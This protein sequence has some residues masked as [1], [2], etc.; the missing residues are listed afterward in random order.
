MKYGKGVG[1]LV[2]T[3]AVLV[4]GVIDGGVTLAEWLTVGGALA[5]TIAVVALPNLPTSPAVKTV[6]QG[7]S[8]VAS[9]LAAALLDPAGITSTVVIMLAV[10]AA[11]VF[12]VYQ[13][14]NVGDQYA[15]ARGRHA[16]A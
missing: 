11:G 14:P 6:A 16:T 4:V 15:V 5:G 10:Q 13:I 9:G 12:G 2:I 1:S 3:T 7:V 8:V